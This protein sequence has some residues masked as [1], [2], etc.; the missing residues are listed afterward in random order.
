MARR[1]ADRTGTVAPK[2]PTSPEWGF[3]V[4]HRSRRVVDGVARTPARAMMRA[5]GLSDSDFTRPLVGV[6][7]LWNEATP[8]QAAL[9]R[10][11]SAAKGS[12]RSLGGVPREFST[13][14][15]ADGI[16][17]GLPGMRASLVSRE[18][19]ADSI[20]LMMLAHGYD[21]LLVAGAC[22]KSIP[23]ALMAMARLNVPSIFTYGGTMMPGRFRGRDV[24]V[25]DVFEA[26]GAWESGTISLGTLE[27][28]ERSA[29]PGAGT[30]AGLFTAN[31]MAGCAE[32][33]GMALL[34]DATV[35][36]I[37]PDRPKAGARAGRALMHLLWSGIRPRDVLT[38]EAFENAI[39]LDAAMGG[40]TNAV[41]H[42]LALAHEAHVRLTLDDF[43]RISRRTPQIVD[44]R[45]S[46]RF[47]MADLHAAGGIPSVLRRLLDAGLLHGD[48]MTVS[49]ERLGAALEACTQVAT[50]PTIR[51]MARPFR[52][53]G[54][55]AILRGNL[56]PDGAVIKTAHEDFLA[57]AG[58]ARVFDTEASASEAIRSRSIR[59]GDVLV[60]RFQG[61]RGAPGMPELLGVTSSL[62]GHG[63][64]SRVALVTDGRFSGAT[65]GLMVGHVSPEAA[66]GGPLAYLRDGDRIRIDIPRRTLNVTTP[67]F[68]ARLKGPPGAGPP[69]PAPGALEKY[70]RLVQSAA[71]GAI[72]S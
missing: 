53:T 13:I 41:L 52:K 26:V 19:I 36:A 63:L 18:V 6:V 65:R 20:E 25:Q 5:L 55:I 2:P 28:L 72:C 46:G 64:G 70:S 48:C 34:G 40:S 27:A 54:S 57:R 1:Q 32:A 12:V 22:D 66:T 35:P 16:A 30:C 45:P 37:H 44:L 23:A 14:T 8:C 9:P 10:I 11:C 69:A 17:M 29:C 15:V 49:G 61:P 58:P 38:F 68:S 50:H 60:L 7:N 67:D 51:P 59:S 42:L 24:T 33:L 71:R 21:A 39:A 31:T 4:R 3:D 62:V 56:A 43:D 47:V